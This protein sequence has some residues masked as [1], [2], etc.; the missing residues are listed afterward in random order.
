MAALCER[1]FVIGLDGLRGPAILEAPTP[2]L[3][4][5]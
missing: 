4:A 1:V 5:F 3:D 2:N